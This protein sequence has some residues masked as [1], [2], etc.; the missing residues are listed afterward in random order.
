MDSGSRFPVVNIPISLRLLSVVV[1]VER[2]CRVGQLRTGK[3]EKSLAKNLG[4]SSV[5]YWE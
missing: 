1:L 2:G 5:L 3:W 4:G